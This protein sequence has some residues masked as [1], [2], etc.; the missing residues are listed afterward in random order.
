MNDSLT[1][2]G[3]V[4]RKRLNGDCREAILFCWDLQWTG[5]SCSMCKYL[6]IH[7]HIYVLYCPLLYVISALRP[8]T[9]NESLISFQSRC[10][11]FETAFGLKIQNYTVKNHYVTVPYINYNIMLF[12]SRSIYLYT[13]RLKHVICTA[14]EDRIIKLGQ[15]WKDNNC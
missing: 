13:L 12:H 5:I 14:L 7:T 15:M 4:F 10:K 6:F 1:S 2:L 11:R 8:F 9:L 3:V